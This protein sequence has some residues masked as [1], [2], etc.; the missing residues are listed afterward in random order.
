[1]S[2]KIIFEKFIKFYGSSGS[3]QPYQQAFLNYYNNAPSCDCDLCWE[4]IKHDIPQF[5]RIIK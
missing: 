2:N 4:G 3:L 5:V 1:M